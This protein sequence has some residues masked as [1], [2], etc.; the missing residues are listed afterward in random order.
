MRV[1]FTGTRHGMTERQISAI[2]TWLTENM[3]EQFHHGDC[4]GADVQAANIAQSLGIETHAWPPVKEDKRAFHKSDVI[5][6]P[7][8]YLERNRMI[9]MQTRF[10]LACPEQNAPQP[11]GGTWYTIRWAQSQM[12][13]ILIAHPHAEEGNSD[14]ETL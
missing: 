12:R 13:D 11:S 2:T 5:H 7:R 1:G 8:P 14:E 4:I 10:L 3:P 6:R 9:V